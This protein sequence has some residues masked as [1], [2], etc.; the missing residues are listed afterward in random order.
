MTPIFGDVRLDRRQ[1]GDLMAPR[2]PDVVTR[3]QPA[4]ALTTRVGHEVDDRIQACGGHERSMV[5][6]MP[7]LTAGPA[8]TLRAATA[9]PLSAREA[10]G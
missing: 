4:C 10:I 5:P 7:R 2:V 6:R 8:P 1:L 9:N 3:L